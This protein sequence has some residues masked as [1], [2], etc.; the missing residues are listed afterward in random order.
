MPRR[1][2]C[3]FHRPCVSRS[4]SGYQI[5]VT[6]L[7]KDARPGKYEIQL[8]DQREMTRQEREQVR[9]EAELR[10]LV[11]AWAKA[12]VERNVDELRRLASPDFTQHNAFLE[13]PLSNFEE[14]IQNL[15]A[16]AGR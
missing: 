12:V 5:T 6:P 1:R 15:E 8:T 11:A 10:P 14:Y 16:R 7:E 9:A 13:N 4:F 3:A 2:S